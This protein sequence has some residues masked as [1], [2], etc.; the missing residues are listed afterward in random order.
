MKA[1]AVGMCRPVCKKAEEQTLIIF[2]AFPATFFSISW[3]ENSGFLANVSNNK[4]VQL[5]GK[6]M[7]ALFA[8]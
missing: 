3:G 6:E 5:F 1:S 2:S 4:R 8:V 7:T